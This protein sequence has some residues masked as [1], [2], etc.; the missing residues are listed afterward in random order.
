MPT[1]FKI[2]NETKTSMM[3]DEQ[4]AAATQR[5]NGV[6]PGRAIPELH[7]KLFYQVSMMCAAIAE[8][9]SQQGY[10]VT[11]ENFEN[12]V[13]AV[14]ALYTSGGGEGTEGPPGPQGP[15]GPQGEQGPVGPT[16]PQGLRGPAGPGGPA[17]LAWKG[18]WSN[19]TTYQ[20]DDAVG[21]QGASYFCLDAH[22]NVPPTGNASSETYWALLASQGA[23]GPQG[24]AGS[25][26]IQGPE[27]PAGPQGKAGPIGPQG[28]KGDPGAAGTGIPAGGTAG[29]VLVKSSATDYAIAWATRQWT[30]GVALVNPE[31]G[32]KSVLNMFPRA[33]KLVGYTIMTTDTPTAATGVQIFH[34]GTLLAEVSISTKLTNWAAPTNTLVAEGLQ[35][36]AQINGAGVSATMVSVI[37]KVVDY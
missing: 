10:T 4:Y 19:T 28:P 15:A 22:T 35:F 27:G 18:S 23:A 25:Q 11:D 32:Q 2:F 1:N 8:A 6:I 36:Y 13:T 24:P 3:T 34:N 37:A 17:G 7:N 30:A 5:Q 21:Y 31:N 16:G 29:Q 33:G 12:L 14:S 9:L 26:G 20:K